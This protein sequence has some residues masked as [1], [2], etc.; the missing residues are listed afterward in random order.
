MQGTSAVVRGTVAGMRCVERV[1]VGVNAWGRAG[2][3]SAGKTEGRAGYGI[4]R[5]V[6]AC[7]ADAR[8]IGSAARV[9]G[10]GKDGIRRL[11]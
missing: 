10:R 4:G 8:E 3:G 5:S 6:R 7:A 2:D 1:H 11:P 9:V